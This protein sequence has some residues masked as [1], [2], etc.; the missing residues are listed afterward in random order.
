MLRKD[1]KGSGLR[2]QEAATKALRRGPWRIIGGKLGRSQSR[3]RSLK[4]KTTNLFE[5][6]LTKEDF[7]YFLLLYA[8]GKEVLVTT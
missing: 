3:S 5:N 7:D 8:D 4:Y 1:L 6:F 2:L